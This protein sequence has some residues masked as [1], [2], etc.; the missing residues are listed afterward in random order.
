MCWGLENWEKIA[1]IVGDT[2]TVVGIVATIVIAPRQLRLWREEKRDTKRAE[3]AGEALVA[4]VRFTT[5]LKS[6]RSPFSFST[7]EP[8]PPVAE[9]ERQKFRRDEVGLRAM[10]EERWKAFAATANQFVDAWE[11]A[12]VYLKPEAVAVF[13]SLWKAKAGVWAGQHTSLLMMRQGSAPSESIWERGF[14]D[15][16][17]QELEQ[18]RSEALLKLG[19]V[20]RL[21][22]GE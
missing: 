14:G 2:A 5:E 20:A 7:D 9:T 4:I 13:D 1:S 10:L 15:E 3:V 19:P 22:D 8:A 21:S 16:I 18:L 12:Q 6:I 11:K 17:D